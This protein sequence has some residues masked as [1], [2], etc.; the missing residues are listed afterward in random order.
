[1]KKTKIVATVG[2]ASKRPNDLAA[3]IRAGVDV[4][5]INA[6]HCSGPELGGWI[7]IVRKAA[8]Q[9]RRHVAILVDLQGPRIRTGR[10]KDKKP[11]RLD[12][13]TEISIKIG[14][15]PGSGLT[16]TTSCPQ[17]ARLVNK[18]DRILLDN[19]MMELEVLG[20]GK[21][22]V[23]CRVVTGGILGENK[24]VN[25]PGAPDTFPSMTAKD[26]A[27]LAVAVRMG[28]DY[29]GLS[30]VRNAKDVLAVRKAIK[31]QRR[32]A[33]V[34]AKIEKPQAVKNIKAILDA[35]DGI[36]VARGD[37]GIELGVE[38]VP[39]V[40]KSL[41][42]LANR[43]GKP[44]ITAT[45]MLESMMNEPRP[46]RAEVSDIANAVFDGT[47]AVMLSGETANG[48]YPLESVRTMA[49]IVEEAETPYRAADEHDR[50]EFF[51]A[52]DLPVHAITIAACDAA[53][54]LNAKAIVAFTAT[55]GTAMLVS[56]LRPKAKIIALAP[57]EK[58][59]RLLN[60]YWGVE[61]VRIRYSRSSD[62]M[63]REGE[64]ALLRGNFLRHG[65][66]IVI[67]SGRLALPA[68]R[69]IAKI[70][71]IGER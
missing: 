55:G 49:R 54:D 19:G 29:V 5:R 63:I 70:H 47:D 7:R 59:C 60:L 36:M 33:C 46:S 58:I 22:E 12:R 42:K 11:I 18:S 40:Q 25:L 53:I 39:E 16:I 69:Y 32:D 17:F 52:R 13:G 26:R 43:S 51:R 15:Q 8:R 6:S 62:G 68:A 61:A 34:I 23:V 64:R 28:V 14:V 24:G 27:D 1:M 20:T 2:P 10:L 35:A 67:V 9:A 56:K 41:I 48:K 3:L 38:K 31:R 21:K 4:C 65:D 30:F 50:G 66:P 45:Q 44:V 57:T 37:L 71:R